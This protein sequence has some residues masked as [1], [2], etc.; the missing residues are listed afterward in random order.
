MR[1][2][3]RRSFFLDNEQLEE[4]ARLKVSI[5]GFT[6][7]HISNNAKIPLPELLSLSLNDAFGQLKAE[8]YKEKIKD[9]KP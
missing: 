7:K 4:L 3:R 6:A 1:W 9:G 2:P 5:E 8:Q